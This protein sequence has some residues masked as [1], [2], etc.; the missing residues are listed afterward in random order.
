MRLGSSAAI[1]PRSSL[2]NHFL[3]GAMPRFDSGVKAASCYIQLCSAYTVTGADVPASLGASLGHR[4]HF[5]V[6][7]LH[8]QRKWA[9]L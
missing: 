9:Y 5:V 4:L 2:L 7:A 1:W 3:N 8:M 6:P